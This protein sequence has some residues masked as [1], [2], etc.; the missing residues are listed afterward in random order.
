MEAMLYFC[1][2]ERGSKES[3]FLTENCASSITLVLNERSPGRYRQLCKGVH[4]LC[5]PSKVSDITNVELS[6]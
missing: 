1:Y 4:E 6:V 3:K 5:L 2:N